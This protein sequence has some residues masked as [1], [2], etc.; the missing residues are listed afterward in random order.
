MKLKLFMLV[1]VLQSA[2]VLGTVAV[3]EHS[4]ASGKLILLETHRVDPRDLLRGDYLILNY[5]VGEIPRGLFSPPMAGELAPGA[6]VYVILAPATNGFFGVVR[7]ST[8]VI[9]PS[10]GEVLMQGKSDAQWWT[11]TNAVHVEYGIEKYFIAEGTG[12]PVGKLTVQAAVPASGHPRIKDVLL[13]G[14]P[15]AK[16]MR[17]KSP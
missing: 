13:D 3:E 1:L 5:Q 12:N 7:A 9:T 17:E 14:R 16:A 2:W 15:Y 10:A 8:N 6:R 4:L 11:G